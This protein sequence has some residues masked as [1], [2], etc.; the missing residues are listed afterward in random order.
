MLV[1]HSPNLWMSQLGFSL[2]VSLLPPN[3]SIAFFYSLTYSLTYYCAPCTAR[4]AA[5]RRPPSPA[6]SSSSIYQIPNTEHMAYRLVRT[7]VYKRGV[8][9]SKC[10]HSKHTNSKYTNSKCSHSKYTNSTYMATPPSC[11]CLLLTCVLSSGR[12]GLATLTLLT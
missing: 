4:C 2:S 10:S 1:R 6:H 5:L 3:P 8:A 12:L 9:H 11:A 7:L